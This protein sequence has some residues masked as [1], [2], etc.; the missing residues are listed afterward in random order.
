MSMKPTPENHEENKMMRMKNHRALPAL[1]KIV[2]TVLVIG[3]AL[4]KIAMLFS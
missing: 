3:Y 2:L 1:S 4:G